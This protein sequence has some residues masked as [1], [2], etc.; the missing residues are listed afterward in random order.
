[1]GIVSELPRDG[2]EL[3]APAL[4][5]SR[6]LSDSNVKEV[7]VEALKALFAISVTLLSIFNAPVQALPSVKTVPTTV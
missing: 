3:K 1:M 4:I 5:V 6:A 2:R 7:I